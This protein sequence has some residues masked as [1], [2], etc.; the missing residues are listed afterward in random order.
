M[1][2]YKRNYRE[3]GIEKVLVLGLDLAALA[4]SASRLGFKVFY[5]EYFGDRD[6][7]SVCEDGFSIIKQVKGSS[8]GRI[9]LFF[10]PDKLVKAASELNRRYGLD[11]CILSSGLEDDFDAL[12]ELFDELNVYGNSLETIVYIRDRERFFNTLRRMN[13]PHPTTFIA[14]DL[15]EAKKYAKDIGYPVVLKPTFGLGGSN[16]ILISDKDELEC[17]YERLFHN[18]GR[19][20]VQKFIDGVHMSASIITS[21]ESSSVLTINHQLLGLKLTGQMESFGYC[22]NIVPTYVDKKLEMKMAEITQKI[23]SSFHLIGSNGI[24]FVYSEGTPFIVEVNP[25]FQGTLECVERTL[26]IN[27]LEKHLDACLGGKIALPNEKGKFYTRMILF[28]H[29]RTQIPDLTSFSEVR[30]IPHEGVIIEEG[31]PVCSVVTSGESEFESFKRAI[32]KAR[33][34]YRFIKSSG[35]SP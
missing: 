9:S 18:F 34:V 33:S 6:L 32:E 29:E 5:S 35:K 28:A 20:I 3:L 14:E 26:R 31:E 4:K 15:D 2:D 8:C 24:D 27:L 1:S 10:D 11:A 12:S 30:D 25:R 13:I 17:E 23:A 21:K 16:I 7:L 22:G 19:F